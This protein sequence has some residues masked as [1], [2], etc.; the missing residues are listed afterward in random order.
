MMRK[1][2]F[3]VFFLL[4]VAPSCGKDAQQPLV[5]DDYWEGVA[6]DEENPGA[7]LT[8]GKADNLSH[9][10]DVPTD[11][12]ELVAPEIIVSLQQLTLHVFDRQTGFSR[13]FPVGVGVKNSDGISVTPTGHFATG[14]D[15]S[16]RW[17]YIPRRAV[18][19]HFGG[20][21][22]LRLTAEN[23]RGQD[24]YGIHGPITE[25]LIR[26]YVSHGCIRMEGS[27]LVQVYYLV[28]EHASTP[29]TIQREP[30]LDAAGQVVDLGSN[31]TL[32]A[33]GDTIQYGD[34]VGDAPPRDDTGTDDD[35]CADDRLES[36]DPV[37]LTPELYSHLMIC[38]S[39]R[40][41]YRIHVPAGAT[42]TVRIEFS[43]A[44]ADLDLLLTDDQGRVLDR[45]FS[46]SDEEEVQVTSESGGDYEVTVYAYEAGASNTYD[47]HIEIN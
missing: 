3:V 26:G 22:F 43:N 18:P 14:P 4:A 37:T 11:L 33:P 15:I 46:T 20:W 35:G 1:T 34:S 30:E 29:V 5:Q 39:D 47:L 25:H 7:T 38:P 12:P 24:T 6:Y 44:T 23:S 42:L 40:D 9:V 13:V 10:Y 41:V 36:E 28:N 32:W 2:W 27:D 45:S 8:P 16:D 21:P 17:W 19:A 31:V